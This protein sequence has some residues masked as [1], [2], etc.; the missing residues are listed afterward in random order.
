MPVPCPTAGPID[1]LPGRQC[2]R[3]Q[4]PFPADPDHMAGTLPE[5]WLCV[6][7]RV[8]LLGSFR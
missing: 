3:C 2:G 5:W 1:H 8:I 6:E 4:R 7:C